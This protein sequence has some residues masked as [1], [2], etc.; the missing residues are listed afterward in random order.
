MTALKE[1]MLDLMHNL[2]LAI[3]D[4]GLLAPAVDH[5]GVTAIIGSFLILARTDSS[6]LLRVSEAINI[7]NVRW[8]RYGPHQSI[9]K[10]IYKRLDMSLMALSKF[11]RR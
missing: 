11:A 1:R 6:L 7:R 2:A 4:M 10:F 8:E 3:G 5:M 9:I